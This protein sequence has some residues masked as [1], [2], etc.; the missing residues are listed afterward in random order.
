[1]G[2]RSRFDRHSSRH[3]PLIW[4][5]LVGVTAVSP[6]SG[7]PPALPVGGTI[8]SG[9]AGILANDPASTVIVQQSSKA[10]INWQS[11]SVGA[12]NTVSFQ[13]PDSKAITLNRVTGSGAS[14]IDGNILANGQVWLVNRDGLLFGQ[15]SQIQVGGLLATTSDIRDA[16]FLSG[17][18]D[19][20]LASG[21]PDA[22]VVN[23]GSVKAATGGSVLLS[24]NR[25]ANQGMIQARLGKVVLGGASTFSVSFDGDKLLQYQVG[26]RSPG[27]DGADAPALVS[28]SGTIRA[29]G[30][31]VL[32]TARA[33]RGVIDN[34]VNTSGIIQATSVSLQNGE[35]VLDAG[36]GGAVVTGTVDVSGTKAG[37]SGG[38]IAV[39]GESLQVGNG[40]QL[41]ASGDAKGG[42]IKIGSDPHDSES[43]SASRVVV[44]GQAS[45][46]A[47]AASGNGGTIA[48]VSADQTDV[49][50]S[51]SA[52]GKIAGG[53]VETSG[54]VLRVSQSARI[55][56]AGPVG[57]TGLWLLDPTD[58][59][60][61]AAMAANIIS[62]LG[63]TN[64]SVT[65]THDIN[66]NAPIVYDSANS[67][68]LLAG[69]D[70]FIS[71]PVLN[72]GAG[73]MVAVGG[74]DGVTAV[75]AIPTTAGAYC[76]NGGS[77]FVAGSN[78]SANVAFGSNLGATVVAAQDLVLN[79]Q[80]GY[81]QVGYSSVGQAPANTSAPIEVVLKGQLTLNGGGVSDA[82]AQIGHGGSGSSGSFAGD[83]SVSASG[84]VVLTAGSGARAYATIGN[85]GEGS[86]GAA[87]GKVTVAS[88]GDVTFN[89]G[90]TLTAS[91]AGDALVLASAGNFT[92]QAGAL[93]VSG[94]GRWLVF[95]DAP[96]NNK[97]SG[98]TA[99]PFYNRAFD[100]ATNT[101]A[102]IGSA[103]NRFVYRLAPSVTV[104]A[105]NKSKIYGSA[106]PALSVTITGGLAADAAS[107]LF[108]GA[109]AIATVAAA[110]SSVGDYAIA[111]S[112]GT[113]TPDFNYGFQFVNGT[114]HI[115]PA[116][117]T[118]SLAGTVRKSYDGG[119][120][121]PLSGVTYQLAGLLFGDSVTVTGPATG[122]YDTS[123]AGTG[124][125]V[126]VSGLSLQGAGSANYVLASS[127][128]AAA[129]GTIDPAILSVALTGAARKTYDGTTAAPLFGLSYRLA[130]LLPGDS[131]TLV[132]PAAATFDSKNAGAG[133]SVTMTGLSL[134]G[135]DR[136]NYLLAS[137]NAAA[138]IGTIDPA[139]LTVALTGTVQK[140]FDGT[141]DA[142]LDA[143]NIVLEGVMPA[144]IVAPALP[145]TGFY[146][147]RDVGTAK[148]V[149]ATNLSVV[150]GDSGNYVLTSSS[151]S[152]AIG[153]ITRNEAASI[154]GNSYTVNGSVVFAPVNVDVPVP[155]AP[156]PQ[157][158][159]PADLAGL[160]EVSDAATAQ[161]GRSL[162]ANSGPSSSAVLIDG[163]LRQFSPQAGNGLP[164]AIP[165]YG[166]VYSSWGNE[167]FWQ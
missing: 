130:G 96:A 34:V 109:P 114:L 153:V 9:Q 92:G 151:A 69:H 139:N 98:L 57:A 123:G 83:I 18:Y 71:N 13:Q 6:A 136:A 152:S 36:D 149:T 50:A 72:R 41:D 102:P 47:N 76:L 40:A 105:D 33:A 91:A 107:G 127:N 78:A 88:G 157:S 125:L 21:N 162:S 45:I 84:R 79:G 133:K 119:T 138:A 154:L 85:G 67:L 86:S 108:T 131:V 8:V 35:V 122:R 143:S 39:K 158:Q 7:G 77:V 106:N 103:G 54:Q 27:Q 116:T 19:F 132:G 75:A 24:G 60:I 164:R 58:V 70:L 52:R 59:S 28:N 118:A 64:V 63:S 73:K 110:N 128:T 38:V 16:D 82:F 1:M 144:D 66:V 113:L 129:I 142:L 14:A 148:T 65:A 166:E 20:G 126:S 62:N 37:E 101:Y 120:A 23:Q 161:I 156:A 10:I 61:D 74:W 163:L 56:T 22:A 93:N 46:S 30:G 137:P 155:A 141:V 134:T 90:A 124:K 150:G 95:M 146:D 68:A 165:P 135:P 121:A 32:M 87:S 15:G 104:T 31:T 5:I 42:T 43:G 55:D 167:A 117:V 80:N 89:S 147:N 115:D 94:G 12:G 25:V 51:L 100:F 26:A 159:G 145:V 112:L 3:A 99:S 160:D 111:P 11:F 4:A 48:I 49:A 2:N 97:A 53:T 44:V 81:A 140:V 29:E 17:R